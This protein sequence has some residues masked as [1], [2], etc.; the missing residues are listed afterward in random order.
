MNFVKKME[1]TILNTYS[2][3]KEEHIVMYK[4]GERSSQID[5]VLCGRKHLKEIKDC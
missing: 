1:V 3:T 5:Y 4:S 2:M